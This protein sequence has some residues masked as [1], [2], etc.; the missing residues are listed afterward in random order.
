MT[1][2]DY[3]RLQASLADKGH[4]LVHINGYYQAYGPGAYALSRALHYRVVR[5]QR[6]WGEV[7][8]CGFPDLVLAKVC[9]QLR[10]AR[11]DMEPLSNNTFLVYGLDGTPDETMVW[12]AVE[13]P[14]AAVTEKPTVCV[15]VDWLADAVTSYNIVESSPKD[16]MHFIS[17]LQQCLSQTTPVYDIRYQPQ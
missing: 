14:G 15:T 8:T 6:P 12:N 13:P 11:A 5:R 16:A 1:E 4:V 3:I 9:L 7:L 10:K 2:Q 17:H